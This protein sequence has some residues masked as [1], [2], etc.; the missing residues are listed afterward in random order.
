M[1]LNMKTNTIKG[2]R[3]LIT[4]HMDRSF[5]SFLALII[6]RKSVSC[7]LYTFGKVLILCYHLPIIQI[8]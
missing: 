6:K 2:E 3:V 5:I 8:P 7:D 4:N 1:Y